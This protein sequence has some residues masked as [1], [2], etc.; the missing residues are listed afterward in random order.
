MKSNHLARALLILFKEN[1]TGLTSKKFFAFVEFMGLEPL[2]PRVWEYLRNIKEEDEKK[3]T[4]EII[5]SHNLDAS[6]NNAIKKMLSLRGDAPQKNIIDKNLIGGF[7][8]KHNNV[9][10]DA[11]LDGQL[12]SL[13]NHLKN[14]Y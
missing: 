3:E 12:K 8:V 10:Y 1:P 5:S 4:I 11:S 7:I 9:I 2:L 14:E 6:L 13:K